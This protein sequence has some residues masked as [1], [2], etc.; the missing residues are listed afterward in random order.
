MTFKS[1]FSGIASGVSSLFHAAGQALGGGYQEIKSVASGTGKAIETQ[2]G[3][4]VHE[5]AGLANNLVKTGSNL[6]EHTEDAIKS[7]IS[8]PLILIG[9]AIAG[10]MIFHGGDVVKTAGQVATKV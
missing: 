8:T 7:T 3:N 2:V 10:L 6:I 9:A 5:G 4:I 1:F